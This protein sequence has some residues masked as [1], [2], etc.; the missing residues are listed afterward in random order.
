MPFVCV[1]TLLVPWARRNEDLTRDKTDDRDAMLIGRL[2]GELRCYEPEPTDPTWT[3][4]R[5]LGARRERLVEEATGLEQQMRDLL[6][7]ARPAVLTAAAQP[8][9]SATWC[10]A[11]DVALARAT[12]PAAIWAARVGWDRHGSRRRWSRVPGAPMA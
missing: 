8:F 6:E 12:R 9:N 5:H 4:L 11:L 7:C 3:R 1:Q 10:A 2:A